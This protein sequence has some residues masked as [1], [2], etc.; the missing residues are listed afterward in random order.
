MPS[1]PAL[2]EPSLLEWARRSANLEPIA[3]ARKIGVPEG[4]VEQWERGEARPTIAQ[5]R[6]AANVY[7]RALAV[8]FLPEPPTG[9]ETLRDFR[10]LAV[11]VQSE[12]SVALHA[13]YR[14]AHAQRDVLLELAELDDE[15]LAGDWRLSSTP[16]ED[17]RM[18]ELAR[19]QLRSQSALPFPTPGGDERKHL[20]FWTNALEE[21]GVLVMSTQ[22]GEVEVAEMRAFSLYFDDVPVIMLNGADATRG[23]V[24][25]LLHEY[26]HLLLHT[27][28]LCDTTTDTRATTADRALEARC[29]AIAAAILL[30]KDLV[31]ASHLVAG[32]KA[33]ESWSLRDLIEAAKPFGVSVEAFLRRL[34]TLGR[35]PLKSYQE[36][37]E[38]QESPRAG[39]RGSGGNFYSTKARDLGK[40]YVRRVSDGHRRALIDTN[41]AATYLDVKAG[42]ISK[43]ARASRV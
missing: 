14:R 5:L 15:P 26:V 28:G 3:A 36:F 42:Q 10:R 35:V 30:P 43:L 25:S 18:A 20:N 7:K 23:R 32:H 13:E 8:F 16:S 31:M 33:G 39:S 12:W 2:V 40:G 6:D 29:N 41:T 24:F 9:F 37:H 11:Q 22:G 38:R 4:R 17:D 1:I 34:V 21:S 19:G 27:E